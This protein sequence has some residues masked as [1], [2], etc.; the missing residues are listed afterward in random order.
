MADADSA[1]LSSIEAAPDSKVTLDDFDA[2]WKQSL[3]NG[4]KSLK[5][6]VGTLSQARQCSSTDADDTPEQEC[7]ENDSQVG[8]SKPEM[9]G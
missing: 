7:K 3:K 6:Q 5:K 2:N 4:L 9:C 1:S 8:F